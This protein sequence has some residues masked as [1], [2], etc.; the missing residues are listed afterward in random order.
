VNE[1]EGVEENEESDG[2]EDSF[3]S[4]VLHRGVKASARAVRKYKEK[5]RKHKTKQG[6]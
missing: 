1:D 4:Y 3:G 2:T 6:I 5:V